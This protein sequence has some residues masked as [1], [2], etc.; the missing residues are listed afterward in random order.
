MAVSASH[1]SLGLCLREEHGWAAS[2]ASNEQQAVASP[3][4]GAIVL[5]KITLPQVALAAHS[6][7]GRVDDMMWQPHRVCP[8]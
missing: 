6:G 4:K 2:V 7:L 5:Y 8:G 1:G 3:S